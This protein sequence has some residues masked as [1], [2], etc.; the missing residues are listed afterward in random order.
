MLWVSLGSEVR[1]GWRPG[2]KIRGQEKVLYCVASKH[3]PHC[4][5]HPASL[6]R[7]LSP[8]ANSK[9]NQQP[10]QLPTKHTYEEPAK[11]SS[12]SEHGRSNLLNKV[13]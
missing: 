6:N 13:G 1:R 12:P 3:T 11:A 5:F 7:L 8:N 4:T 9:N 10:I 2:E